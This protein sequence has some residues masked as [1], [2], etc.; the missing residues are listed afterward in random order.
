MVRN[1]IA[2]DPATGRVILRGVRV[3]GRLEQWP[4]HL[5]IRAAM[6]RSAFRAVRALAFRAAV[7]QGI[8]T[9]PAVSELASDP[10]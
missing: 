1:E 8:G 9:W 6:A 3:L 7:G 2:D 5:G 4:L 10:A